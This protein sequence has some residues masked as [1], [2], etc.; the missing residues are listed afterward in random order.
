MGKALQE[1]GPQQALRFGAYTLAMAFMQILLF[2]QLRTLFLKL[3]GAQIG[4]ST[5]I[6]EIRFFNHYRGGF[7]N[8]RAGDQCFVGHDCLIDL[9][10]PVILEDQVTLAERVTVLTHTNVGYS[11]HPLQP[12]F[13]PSTGPVSFRQGC[14]VG[15][16]ATVLPNVVVGAQAFVAAGAVVTKDVPPRTVVAGVP[17]RFIRQIDA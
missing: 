4:T 1:I 9:A 10:A 2:P 6:H 8:L 11:D 16:C 12:Y 13:P 7:S 15:A 5:I 17:A 3:L 14:F